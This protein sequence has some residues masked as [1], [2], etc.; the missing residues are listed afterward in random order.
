MKE[1]TFEV[2]FR[3]C[4]NL[5]KTYFSGKEFPSEQAGR[6]YVKEFFGFNDG[7]PTLKL[8]SIKAI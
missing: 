4:G 7:N 5:G 3:E 6:E 2:V 1:Y 8:I